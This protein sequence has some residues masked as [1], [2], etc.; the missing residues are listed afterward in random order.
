MT[1]VSL[2]VFADMAEVTISVVVWL[3]TDRH[4]GNCKMITVVVFLIAA[5]L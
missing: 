1:L 4:C 5:D 2:P 3:T